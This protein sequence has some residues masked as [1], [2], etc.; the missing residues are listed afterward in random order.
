VSAIYKPGPGFPLWLVGAALVPVA[1]L[2]GA[3][4]GRLAMTAVA[5]AGLA[6]ILAASAVHDRAHRTSGEAAHSLYGTDPEA[7]RTLVKVS[8]GLAAVLVVT[9]LIALG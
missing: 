4:A 1:F 3:V 2:T 8:M 6:C 9:V 5:G 7:V